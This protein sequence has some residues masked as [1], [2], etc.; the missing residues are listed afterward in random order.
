[1]PTLNKTLFHDAK[2]KLYDMT[3]EDPKA[4]DYDLY[5]SLTA[6]WTV[7]TGHLF[8]DP[9]PPLGGSIPCQVVHIRHHKALQRLGLLKPVSSL[10]TKF[11]T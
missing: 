5:I 2:I 10:S 3:E 4:P 1:M 8:P 11:S 7:D 6:K 9:L